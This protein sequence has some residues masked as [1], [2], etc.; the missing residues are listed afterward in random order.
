MRLFPL[1]L[2][3]RRAIAR[4]NRVENPLDTFDHMLY[5]TYRL[6][7]NNKRIGHVH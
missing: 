6:N 1:Q 2:T 4:V 5:L 3:V 7:T